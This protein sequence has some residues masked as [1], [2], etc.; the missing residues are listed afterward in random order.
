MIDLLFLLNY[1]YTSY[2]M[3]ENFCLLAESVVWAALEQLECKKSDAF[4]L[5]LC[6]Q[7]DLVFNYP[8]QTCQILG[9]EIYSLR[10][11]F[12]QPC[13]VRTDK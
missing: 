10:N 4:G 6:F 8:S 12:A 13:I 2:F 11:T 9:K 7:M 1:D 3:S 5:T